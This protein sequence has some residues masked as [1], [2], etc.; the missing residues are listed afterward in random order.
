MN[1][2]N[3][4]SK[5]EMPHAFVSEN[6]W[7]RLWR[8]AIDKKTTLVSA[9]HL[10]ITNN[11]PGELAPPRDLSPQIN[12]TTIPVEDEIANK[13]KAYSK[14]YNITNSQVIKCILEKKHM[15][16]Q[17]PPIKNR[18]HIPLR[19]EDYIKLKSEIKGTGETMNS[20]I[21]KYLNNGK[22]TKFDDE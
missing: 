12:Y 6:V 22:K 9:I 7:I 21:E 11:N 18:V 13:I 4:K 17:T 15:K 16:M 2:K 5:I 3:K 14:K 8:H 1:T 20:L 19:D 10:V